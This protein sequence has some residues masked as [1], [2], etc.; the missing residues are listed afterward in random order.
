MAR[1]LYDRDPEKFRRVVNI[2]DEAVVPAMLTPKEIQREKLID[3]NGYRHPD[4]LLTVFDYRNYYKTFTAKEELLFA[5]AFKKVPK[6]FGF[7]AEHL[8]G[9]TAGECIRYY[10]D[11]KF[12]GRFK[13]V[14]ETAW[15]EK[16]AQ[17]ESMYDYGGDDAPPPPPVKKG[18][19]GHMI[20]AHIKQLRDMLD[21]Q[22]QLLN[23]RSAGVARKVTI[24]PLPDLA[25][26]RQGFL[27]P[28]DISD[29][30]ILKL[31]RSNDV[32]PL[33][34]QWLEP[35]YEDPDIK[36]QMEEMLPANHRPWDTQLSEIA[37]DALRYKDS[38]FELLTVLPYR[39][40]YVL[41]AN[42]A[43]RIA[44]SNHSFFSSFKPYG[45]PDMEQMV[46]AVA[47]LFTAYDEVCQDKDNFF[48]V[49][50]ESPLAQPMGREQRKTWEAKYRFEGEQDEDQYVKQRSDANKT[51]LSPHSSNRDSQLTV[52]HLLG[53]RDAAAAPSHNHTSDK[54]TTLQEGQSG[55]DKNDKHESGSGERDE[56]AG[57]DQEGFR[58]DDTYEGDDD[59]A[60]DSEGDG[61]ESEPDDSDESESDDEMGEP[62]DEAGRIYKAKAEGLYIAMKKMTAELKGVKRSLQTSKTYLTEADASLA[63]ARAER[64]WYKA[65]LQETEEAN[66]E[67]T[68]RNRRKQPRAST[69]AQI[70]GP[71]LA[72]MID[73]STK[74]WR[75]R[76]ELE[77]DTDDTLLN[78]ENAMRVVL[79]AGY[80]RRGSQDAAGEG[81]PRDK[82]S[83]GLGR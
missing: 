76:K 33:I 10:N 77:A 59:Q 26:V 60:I 47:A 56:Y 71:E 3:N 64:D 30:G 15:L 70:G 72:T 62:S 75:K 44:A 20:D 38:D 17:K 13:L 55:A 24:L 31:L 69:K 67:E 81:A 41:C 6:D 66:T 32:L 27:P 25:L 37:A 19:K 82:S 54:Y 53:R 14:T 23:T 51:V 39:E 9:R 4:S 2:E 12:D 46:V 52:D 48:G 35:S 29:D 34:K 21:N 65:R 57:Q 5:Q 22:A 1:R 45:F 11:H 78:P 40:A 79:Q 49:L 58:G 80:G 61:D 42:H 63:E 68:R 83:P 8:P 36:A 73:D 43:Y 74:L 50:L 18:I 28:F 16:L 7:I